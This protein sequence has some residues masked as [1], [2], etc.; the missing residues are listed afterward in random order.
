MAKLNKIAHSRLLLQ[1]QEAKEMGLDRLA[2]GMFFALKLAEE[3][4]D[5][6]V[7]KYSYEQMQ[8]EIYQELWELVS[9]VA[10]YY[11]VDDITAEKIDDVLQEMRDNFLEK[12]EEVLGVEE[13]SVGALEPEVPGETK[14]ADI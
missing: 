12:V 3:D 7:S 14:E 6:P 8:E 9:K 11:D 2:R 10:Q 5:M 1:A 13:G 4:A